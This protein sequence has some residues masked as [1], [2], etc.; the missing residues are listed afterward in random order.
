MIIGI[1]TDIISVLRI[2]NAIEK[3]GRFI[4]KNFTS[5]EIAFFAERSFNPQ[6]IAGNFAAKEAFAK[7]MGTG[8]RSFSLKDISVLRNEN[9]APY[10]SFS[11]KLLPLLEKANISSAHIS[12]SNTEEYAIAFVVCEGRDKI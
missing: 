2:S 4:E 7:A 9:G 8:F 11:P 1:G 10:F 6:K 5:E 12:I 3:T